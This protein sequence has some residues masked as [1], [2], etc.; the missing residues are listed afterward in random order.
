MVIFIT[1]FIFWNNIIFSTIIHRYSK[2]YCIKRVNE[3]KYSGFNLFERLK[4][5]KNV[6]CEFTG[7]NNKYVHVKSCL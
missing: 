7:S 2:E 3:R 6:K 1:D 4:D 5:G